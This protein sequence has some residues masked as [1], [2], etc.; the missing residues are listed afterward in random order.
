MNPSER[1][2]RAAMDVQAVVTSFNQGSMILEAVQSLCAQTTPPAGIILVDDGSTDESSLRILAQ[3]ESDPSFCVPIT[4]LRQPNGGVSAARNAGIRSA[5]APLVLVLDGDD[6]L[7]PAYIEQVS[8]L[9]RE[10]SGLVA[11][12]SWMRTF[13]VLDATVCPAGGGITAFLSR[14]CCPATHI[15]RR[16]AWEQCGG[17]DE[18]MR[19]GFED[20]DFFLSL[21]ETVP[22]AWIGI[23][24]EPLIDYRTAPASSNVR[25][26]EK[27]LELMQFLIEKHIG[28]Y[29]EHITDAVLGVE[30]VSMA[31]LFGW[32]GEMLQGLSAGQELCGAS[33]EFLQQPSYGDGGMAAA[34]RIASALPARF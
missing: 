19:S 18:T 29:R 4:V 27:R 22:E 11:A 5:Q 3:I 31:R 17:Y 15:L 16:G 7:K 25:S 23:V 28:S 24:P 26:M 32:E 9:L 14:N 21:L 33:A 20:W 2:P 6:R 1:N 30:A 13:G 8:G 34:V 10:R 12:S